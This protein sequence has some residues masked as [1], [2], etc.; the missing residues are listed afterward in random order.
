MLQTG[1][2]HSPAVS[3]ATPVSQ[4]VG[5]PARGK[6]PR[7]SELHL[8]QYFHPAIGTMADRQFSGRTMR[9]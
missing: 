1:S 9:S 3:D 6:P 4:V 5:K 8:N 7:L 2:T